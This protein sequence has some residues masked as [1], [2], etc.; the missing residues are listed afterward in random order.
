VGG[1]QSSVSKISVTQVLLLL[2]SFSD[3]DGKA[4]WESKADQIRKVFL[5]C[6]LR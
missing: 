4:K 1:G 6:I 5:A 3:K 2:D